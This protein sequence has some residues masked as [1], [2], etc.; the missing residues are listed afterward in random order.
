MEEED[1]LFKNMEIYEN[2]DVEDLMNETCGNS[3]LISNQKI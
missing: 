1:N 3:L 2:I